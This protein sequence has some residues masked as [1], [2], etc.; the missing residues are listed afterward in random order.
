VVG[1]PTSPSAHPRARPE[2]EEQVTGD[3]GRNG[4]ACRRGIGARLAILARRRPPPR[5]AGCSGAS[6]AA[7][8][9]GSA[10]VA[11]GRTPH[12]DPSPAG[13]VRDPRKVVYAFGCAGP[14]ALYVRAEVVY[15]RFWKSLRGALA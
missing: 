2:T 11:S 12:L 5:S 4:R 6:G 3:G 10:G 14:V 8:G 9:G 1:S 7:G 13:L 15:R